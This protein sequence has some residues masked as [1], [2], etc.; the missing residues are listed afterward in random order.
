MVATLKIVITGGAGFI[1]SAVCRTLSAEESITQIVVLDDL[2]TGSA[3]NIRG[4]DGV[5]LIQGSILND[6]VLCLSLQGASSVVHLAARASVTASTQDPYSIHEI[7]ATGT[8]RVLEACRKLG[9]PHF[10]LASSAAVY[11][12]EPVIPTPESYTP[13]PVSPYAASKLAAESYAFAYAHCFGLGVL[14]LRFFNVYGP[15]QLLEDTNGAVVPAFLFAAIMGRPVTIL[16]DGTQTR[17]LI[18]V[19]SLSKIISTAVVREIVSDRSINVGSGIGTSLLQLVDIIGDLVGRELKVEHLPPRVSDVQ[20][21]IADVRILQE[22]FGHVR[23]LDLRAGLSRTLQWYLAESAGR[24]HGVIG[25]L[26]GLISRTY[27]MRKNG[28]FGESYVKPH[29]RV[30]RNVRHCPVPGSA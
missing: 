1:G 30:T 15:R 29:Q 4:I 10:V 24:T 3:R 5:Q 21:S 20:H 14:S 26:R 22:F 6:N 25:G 27:R 11:G 8:I 28:H 18:F 16:G 12:P 17:D 19:E 13:R 9:V 23:Q 7:D 2:S